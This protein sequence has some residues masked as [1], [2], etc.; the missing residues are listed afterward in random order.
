MKDYIRR[1]QVTIV[2]FVI[3]CIAYYFASQ[4]F[5]Y[6]LSEIMSR[7][8]RNI[9]LVLSLIISVIAGL[10]LNFSIVVGAMA[11]QV[12]LICVTHWGIPGMSGMLVCMLIATPIAIFLGWLV[13]MLFNKTKGQEMI[14]GMIVAFFANGVY[15]FIFLVL[16]GTVIPMADE[17]LMILGGVGVRDTITL[18][19]DMQKVVDKLFSVTLNKVLLYLAITI[20]LYAIYQIFKIVS[21]AKK[22]NVQPGI[23]AI[24]KPLT[25]VAVIFAVYAL[26]IFEP[27]ISSAASFCGVPVVTFAF[28]ALVALYCKFLL[29]TK[30]GQDFR[31]IGMERTVAEAAGI[32]INKKRILANI[33]S[34]VLA[35]WG[36]LIFVQNTTSFSTYSSHENVGIFAIA[37]ILIGGASIKRA[38]ISQ[39][40]IGTV[41]F[42]TLFVLSPLA[43]KNLFNDPTYGEYFR[44]FVAYAVIIVGL[45]IHAIREAKE[46]RLESM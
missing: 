39:A 3:C 44:V 16:V 11:A 40:W 42:H 41:L 27:T 1:Y 30:M 7:L 22:T 38:T 5:S 21:G 12:S 25:K 36:Q 43:G 17:I 24:L 33:M 20:T 15:Q 26:T 8:Q 10:G 14:T 19:A 31:A 32:D 34:T 45:V 6:V 37:A 2:F 35:A 9:V 29:K 18:N 46:R 13:G 4:P 28:A 23:K